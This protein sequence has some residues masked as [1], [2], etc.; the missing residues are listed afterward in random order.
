MVFFTCNG[1]GESVKKAQ[2]E[3]HVNICRG[4]TCL[5]CIDCGKEFWGD[6]YK[7][8]TKCITEDQKYGGKGFEAKAKKGDIKQLQWIQKIQETMNDLKV[9]PS[10]REILKQMDSCE[11]IPRKKL[12][13]QN[14]MKNSLNVKNV[15]LQEE[16]WEIFAA[17]ISNDKISKQQNQMRTQNSKGPAESVDA[18]SH[19][20]AT[21]ENHE[22]IKNKRERKEERKKKSR[23]EEKHLKE[24]ESC[25]GH[26]PSQLEEK[27][28]KK[29]K[30]CG[31]R[32]E[33]NAGE[34]NGNGIQDFQYHSNRKC[35]KRKHSKLS[36]EGEPKSKQKKAEVAKTEEVEEN[37][38][39]KPGKFNW[40]RTIKRVL[41]QS[42]EHEIS[43]KKLRKKV[44][45]HYYTEIGDNNYKSEEDLMVIFQKKIN[46]N[47]KFKVL[48]DK[49]K[50]VK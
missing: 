7:I 28:K 32:S 9:S 49:V 27:E 18:N 14:W 3:K 2:V 10:V 30:T 23:K 46:S 20:A 13:F 38:E 37:A 42:P 6:D 8:H 22:K 39:T 17:V 5:S 1:C 15:A 35:G 43:I 48:K 12:K 11:N 34:E 31:N 19:Q 29:P 50:L 44:L 26:K 41:Q 36:S 16:V 21:A 40:K 25:L 4:C 45:S 24:D 33:V 47:P